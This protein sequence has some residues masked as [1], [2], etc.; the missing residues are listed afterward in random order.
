VQTN[1]S[2]IEKSTQSSYLELNEL[3]KVYNATDAQ[4]NGDVVK[5]S[6]IQYNIEKLDTFIYNYK[7]KKATTGD[8]V[9]ITGY[10][11]EGAAVID[12]LVVN[13]E[14]INLLEDNTRD[15]NSSQ[16]D[17][18]ISKYKISDMYTNTS[19]GWINYYVKTDQGIEKFLY[20]AKDH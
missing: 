11:E 10:T 17:R 6:T 1:S 8:M 14:G 20:S 9:R 4:R 15:S 5:V 2:S 18:V 13:S 3:P 7:N 12:D 19:S 16:N